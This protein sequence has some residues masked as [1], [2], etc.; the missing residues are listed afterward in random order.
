MILVS[1]EA[2][3]IGTGAPFALFVSGALQPMSTSMPVQNLLS[4]AVGLSYGLSNTSSLIIELRKSSF[5]QIHGNGQTVYRDTVLSAGGRSFQN[6]I[7]EVAPASTQS[8]V[9]AYTLGMGY[10]L[11]VCR[12]G[13][14]V[15]FAQAIV[16]VGVAGA[17][18]SEKFGV[19]WMTGSPFSIDFGVRADQLFSR[20][21]A[22]QSSIDID[23]G[24]SFAW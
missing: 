24:V 17:L 10:R 22:P 16:G 2:P 15:P 21:N 12:I 3:A 4:G 23:A 20:V 11:E 5:V 18:T 1:D 13:N 19:Q 14:T 8:T 9:S 6:T 7:G